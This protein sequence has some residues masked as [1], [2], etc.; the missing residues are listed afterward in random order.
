MTKPRFEPGDVVRHKA[1]GERGVI[2]GVG[3]RCTVHLGIRAIAC[4]GKSDE[5]EREFDGTYD[6]SATLGTTL[7][8]VSEGVLETTYSPSHPDTRARE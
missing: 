7:D 1:S 6:L 4:L 5:C 8:D 2:T 3:M